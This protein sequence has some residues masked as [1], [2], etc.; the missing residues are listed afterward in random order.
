MKIIF[1]RIPT[2]FVDLTI[3]KALQSIC[4]KTKIDFELIDLYDN[5]FDEVNIS[6]EEIILF[7]IHT[8]QR[9]DKE[10]EK[11]RNKLPNIKIVVVESDMVY[12]DW[13]SR[14][15][16]NIDFLLTTSL[17][18]YREYSGP[19]VFF[20]WNISNYLIEYSIRHRNKFNFTKNYDLICLCNIGRESTH[21]NIFFKSIIS[22]YK[23][24][25]N[26]KESNIHKVL[27]YYTQ[28]KFVLGT[29]T[30]I[31]GNQKRSTKVMRDWLGAYLD[32]P[33]I[34]DD[35]PE[36]TAFHPCVPV[37]EYCNP[38]SLDY[39]IQTLT[40]PKYSK[41][42]VERQRDH[43]SKHTVDKQLAQF[44]ASIV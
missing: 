14:D 13:Q 10:Y 5:T 8:W 28:S 7:C 30:S 36:I 19:K 26:L 43:I 24:I 25:T 29:S 33:L 6:N 4:H 38:A 40:D 37:Y 21:R 31:L 23:L 17:E 3:G 16:V 34:Y 11:L 42:I 1:A 44:L 22:K 20:D 9:N 15:F 32:V 27:N 12:Q 18:L 2:Q 39:L 41:M 35:F